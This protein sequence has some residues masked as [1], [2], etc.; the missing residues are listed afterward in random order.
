M[1]SSLLER[2]RSYEE[3]IDQYENECAE[4]LTETPK[5]VRG[6]TKVIIFSSPLSG[7]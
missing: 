5:R 7:V 2:A 6:E 3:D 1:S 4:L